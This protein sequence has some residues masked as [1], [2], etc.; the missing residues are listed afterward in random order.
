MIADEASSA[1][2][3][4]AAAASATAGAPALLLPG[5]MLLSSLDFQTLARRCGYVNLSLSSSHHHVTQEVSTATCGSLFS[6]LAPT[7]FLRPPGFLGPASSCRPVVVS[8]GGEDPD[9]GPDGG[10][11]ERA[12]ASMW[13]KSLS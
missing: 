2:A 8:C 11:R 7:G 12:Q 3:A 6:R 13:T 1:A 10:R 4:A 9:T 5:G